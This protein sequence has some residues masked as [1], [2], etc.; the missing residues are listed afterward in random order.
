MNV[1]NPEY[2]N[3]SC[4]HEKSS[5]RVMKLRKQLDIQDIEG[6]KAY[7]EISPKRCSF[8]YW[9]LELYKLKEGK[10]CYFKCN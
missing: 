6:T 1:S 2:M 5:I 7:T 9:W 4:N 10:C 3:A 8:K